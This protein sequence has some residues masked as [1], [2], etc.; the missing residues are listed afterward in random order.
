MK[1]IHI[2]QFSAPFKGGFISALESLKNSFTVRIFCFPL[3]CKHNEWMNEFISCHTVYFLNDDVNES[4]KEILEILILE[5]PDIVHSH[6]DGYDIPVVKA[7]KRFR[8]KSKKKINVIWHKHNFY[9]Y[10]PNPIKKIYQVLFFIIKYSFYGRKVN[11]IFVSKGIKYFINRH[12]FFLPKKYISII[13]PNGI[14]IKKF[15]KSLD[16]PIDD[17]GL[18]AFCT[19]GGRNIQKR[20][21]LLLYAGIEIQKIRSDFKIIITKGEDTEEIIKKIFGNKTPSWLELLNQTNQIVDF[22]ELSSCFVSCSIHETFS[23]AIAE[24]TLAGIPVVQSDIE[25]TLWNAENPSTFMFKSKD[26][27]SLVTALL[28]VMNYNKSE[29]LRKCIITQKRN[30]VAYN[31]NNWSV[32]VTDFC[33]KIHEA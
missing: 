25:G 18:F 15:Y 16:T 24:A 27:S 12:Q 23:N 8:L 26:V 20:I 4:I 22:L 14:D 7:I 10:H 28:R 32:K 33:S 29:L 5:E 19:Y 9:T 13:L 1:I 21:D 31:L 2:S 11:F 6:F 30:L 3:S 17:T